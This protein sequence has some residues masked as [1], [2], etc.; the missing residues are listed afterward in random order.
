MVK[1]LGEMGQVVQWGKGWVLNE[2]SEVA[3]C[4]AELWVDRKRRDRRCVA[5]ITRSRIERSRVICTRLVRYWYRHDV[6][7][8]EIANGVVLSRCK[9]GFGQETCGNSHELPCEQ[10]VTCIPLSGMLELLY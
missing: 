10:L 1:E 8:D 6:A 7:V 4:P 3:K 9:D 5:W 2:G